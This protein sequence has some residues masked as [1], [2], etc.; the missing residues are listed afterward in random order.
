MSAACAGF[1]AQMR[2]ASIGVCEAH[3]D[4]AA[5]VAVK[6]YAAAAD[7]AAPF[8]PST[9]PEKRQNQPSHSSA[10]P[11]VDHGLPGGGGSVAK[12]EGDASDGVARGVVVRAGCLIAAQGLLDP[13]IGPR[14]AGESL[15]KSVLSLWAAPEGQVE[16]EEEEGDQ[17]DGEGGGGRDEGV[18]GC[19]SVRTTGDKGAVGGTTAFLTQET[20]G[21][22]DSVADSGGGEG[23]EPALVLANDPPIAVRKKTVPLRDLRWGL[24]LLLGCVAPY[25]ADGVD[26]DDN[27]RAGSISGAPPAGQQTGGSPDEE[28]VS[29]AEAQSR[30]EPGM[31]SD[32]SSVT[33]DGGSVRDGAAAAAAGSDC[34]GSEPPANARSEINPG[35]EGGEEGSRTACRLVDYASRHPDIGPALV[36]SVL[37]AWIPHLADWGRRPAMSSTT[38]NG[39]QREGQRPPGMQHKNAAVRAAGGA[40]T[41]RPV[42]AFSV[43]KPEACWQCSPAGEAGASESLAAGAIHMLVFMVRRFPLL[44]MSDFSAETL[45]CAAEGSMGFGVRG[46][47]GGK[48]VGTAGKAAAVGETGQ[49]GRSTSGRAQRAGEALMLELFLS[50]GGGGIDVLLPAVDSVRG[51]ASL[52]ERSID[53]VNRVATGK[54]PKGGEGAADAAAAEDSSSPR[55]VRGGEKYAVDANTLQISNREEWWMTSG[56]RKHLV[57]AKILVRQR[58]PVPPPPTPIRRPSG[59]SAL[60]KGPLETIDSSRDNTTAGK[61]SGPEVFSLSDSTSGLALVDMSSSS[62]GTC[63]MD[64]SQASPHADR[65]KNG[66]AGGKDH[67]SQSAVSRGDPGDTRNKRGSGAGREKP[68]QTQQANR[69]ATGGK[70]TS[71]GKGNRVFPIARIS[72]DSF[73]DGRPKDGDSTP[74]SSRI[75]SDA[76]GSRGASAGSHNGERTKAENSTGSTSTAFL[77]EGAYERVPWR[78]PRDKKAK[79]KNGVKGWVSRMF[80]RRK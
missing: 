51:L 54:G 7:V 29:V 10:S 80:R 79:R 60:G 69:S 3:L 66:V 59:P 39:W 53:S 77:E 36:A 52:H 43:G 8:N 45:N 17:H 16:E 32:V 73:V 46:A 42:A 27:D 31:V 28:W 57:P 44:P 25:L 33:F 24:E 9:R 21:E 37:V 75:G 41:R 68:A 65:L 6:A 76:S 11:S 62:A 19:G 61:S 4:L 55:L 14:A 12:R 30:D 50:R 70:K 47:G 1:P 56:H 64:S 15:A 18:A 13:A 78:V 71:T 34:G 5:D 63:G 48:G 40:S 35:G 2:E 26:A 38:G 20:F 22:P 23:A 67:E 49:G 72:G 74:A 58:L